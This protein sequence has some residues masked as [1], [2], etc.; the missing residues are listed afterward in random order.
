MLCL[1]LAEHSQS[2]VL[3]CH[4]S[5]VFTEDRRMTIGTLVIPCNS[6]ILLSHYMLK[7]YFH[8]VVIGSCANDTHTMNGVSVKYA[9]DRFDDERSFVTIDQ[10]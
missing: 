4:S 7:K 3:T 8:P 9:K 6:T 10:K 1:G 5:C 2:T